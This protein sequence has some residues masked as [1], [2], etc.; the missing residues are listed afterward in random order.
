M[1]EQ[2]SDEERKKQARLL[3]AERLL[4]ANPNA[5]KATAAVLLGVAEEDYN[6]IKGI[7]EPKPEIDVPKHGRLIS[8]FV[9][10]I[11]K[12]LS[13][14][15]VLFYREDS[16]EVIEISLIKDEEGKEKSIGF[17]PVKPNRMI[18]LIEEHMVP[19]VTIKTTEGF[20]KKRKSINTNLAAVLLESEQLQRGLP[21]IK[22]IF[23]IPLPI[24][25]RG[26]LTF[27]KKGYD[28]RFCSWLP[29]DAPEISNTKMSL[30]DAKIIIYNLF[31]EFCFKD[32]Q[33]YTNAVAAFIT[34]FLRGIFKSF[35]CRTP[36]FFYLANRERAGKDYCAGMTSVL[37]EG[38]ALEEPPICNDEKGN[39][40]S[41]DELRKKVLAALMNGRKR[42]HFSNNRGYINNA[43][44]EGI[45]TAE[46]YSDRLLGKN[47][48]LTL[49]NEIDFS[50]SGNVGVGFTPDLANR[51]RMIRLFLDIE[52]ANQ[53]KFN[54]PNLHL[55][56][57]ENRGLILSALFS[58]VRNWIDEGMK[59]GNEPF[60]SFSEWANICGGIMESAGY[61]SPCKPDRE[62][63]G[64]GGDAETQDMKSLFELCYSEHPEQWINKN[65]MRAIV[66]REESLF[67]YLDFQK[68][69]DQTKFG[70][71][72]K[73]YTGRVLSDIQLKVKDISIRASRQEYM[74]SNQKAE[75]NKN[76]IFGLSESDGN[77]GNFGY[78]LPVIERNRIENI[79]KGQ[80]DTKV[81]EVAKKCYFCNEPTRESVNLGGHDA[82]NNCKL[83]FDEANVEKPLTE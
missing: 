30:E 41:N 35:T 19:M 80:L 23:T 31:N 58:I 75:I 3:T 2:I 67:S 55:Y 83:I 29:Y 66:E 24:I 15:S 79:Y 39:S 12:V 54:N 14:Q 78:L 73:K 11:T 43:V 22:R 26:E 64:L 8:E 74:F 61:G 33:D 34:P 81:D 7:E 28:E 71:L 57:K 20:V 82:C 47:E 6:E 27:P 69:A 48:V 16:R 4:K 17:I 32:K 46:K 40:S 65:A 21:N 59:P 1:E 38:Y 5:D 63:L 72:I 25:Y 42:L 50:L 52:D 76:K 62:T 77:L 44:F 45:I 51:S 9:E 10:D 53:R 13:K 68:K 36:V 18:T 37:Y 60:A 56:I 49:D 70:T